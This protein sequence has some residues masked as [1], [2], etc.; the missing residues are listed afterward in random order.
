MHRDAVKNHTP[1]AQSML[2]FARVEWLILGSECLYGDIYTPYHG[3]LDRR[4]VGWKY[5]EIK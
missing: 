3:G 1:K 4:L 5:E 2:A